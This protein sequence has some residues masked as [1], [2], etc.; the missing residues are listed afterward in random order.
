MFDDEPRVA[1]C[2]NG[3]NHA[4]RRGLRD[5]CRVEKP[6]CRLSSIARTAGF[7]SAILALGSIWPAE[8]IGQARGPSHAVGGPRRGHAGVAHSQMT[9]AHSANVVGQSA[10]VGHG[11]H[12]SPRG[13]LL[14]RLKALQ[15]IQPIDAL[16]AE[17]IALE[18]Q[19]IQSLLQG[20]PG[21]GA[22]NLNAGVLTRGAASAGAI[23]R[24]AGVSAGAAHASGRSSINHSHKR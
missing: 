24:N 9:P 8:A 17:A 16:Q 20:G 19:E 3:T 15:A 5:S 14:L 2:R 18:I 23:N 22:I 7:F 4:R 21:V 10:V 13:Q 1:D 11:I 12:Q 6:R